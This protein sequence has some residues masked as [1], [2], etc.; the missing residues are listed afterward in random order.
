MGTHIGQGD[1]QR[2]ALIEQKEVEKYCLSWLHRLQTEALDKRQKQTRELL[3]RAWI[4]W[5]RSGCRTTKLAGHPTDETATGQHIDK[6][7]DAE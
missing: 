6:E 4:H 2:G 5:S 1:Q 3:A 7:E